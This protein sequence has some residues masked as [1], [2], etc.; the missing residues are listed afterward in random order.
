MKNLTKIFLIAFLLLFASISLFG[1]D[2]L[3]DLEDDEQN[4]PKIDNS[5]DLTEFSPT[6]DDDTEYLEGEKYYVSTAVDLVTEINGNYTIDRP[7]TLDEQNEN[8]RIYHN[9][10]F[11]EGDFFQVIYY[12]DVKALGT[13]FAVMS[14]QSDS[15]FAEIEYGDKGSPLQ[16]NIIKQGIYNLIL[17]IEDFGIDMVKVGDIETPVY[18]TIKSCSLIVHVSLEDHTYTEM[19]LN[20]TTKEY[21]IEKQIPQNA[22]IGFSNSAHTS[23]YK[24]TVEPSISDKLVYWNFNNPTSIQVH[25]GGTYKVYFNAKT[26]VLRL[27]LQNPNTATYFCQVGWN[28]DKVLTAVSSSTPYIFEYIFVAPSSV[29]LP[30]IYPQLGMSYDLTILGDEEYVSSY[31]YVKDK[32]TYKL[33]INLKDFTLGVEKIL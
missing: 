19:T 1:C 28:E 13:V 17:D 27:E 8:K 33:T 9:I 23:R 26:Y 25:V 14:D 21:Y 30:S 31:G 11:Y 16:V 7:F 2:F 5:I 3:E 12:K 15:E 20:S 10:Y 18:E 24:I 22:S 6:T 4:I 32:G 29:D